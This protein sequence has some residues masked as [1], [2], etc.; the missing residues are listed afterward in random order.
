MSPE[1]VTAIA[2]VF[3][4]LVIAASAVAALMQIRH[5]RKSNEIEIIAKWTEAMESEEFGAARAF[6]VTELPRILGDRARLAAL[7]WTPFP[8]EL[9]PVRTISNH[10]ESVGAFIKLGN[11]DEHV[12]CE[13]WGLVV[14]EC[15]RAAS[16]VIQFMREK[17]GTN[18]VWENF[19]YLAVLADRW[20][21]EHP[22]GTYPANARRMP[23]DTTLT[24]AFETVAPDD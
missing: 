6:V 15:W 1:W 5:M 12:A 10:F 3:T 8:T 4:A 19:E 7:S 13:L 2:T 11:V 22:Q 14:L 18:A 24:T 9:Q 23:P 21:T 17:Y 16:P 20:I